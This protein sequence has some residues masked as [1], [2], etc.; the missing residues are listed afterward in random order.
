MK[1]KT[2]LLTGM[3]MGNTLNASEVKTLPTFSETDFTHANEITKNGKTVLSVVLTNSGLEKVK[4][5]NQNGVNK[6]IRFKIDGHVY[7]FKLRE[8]IVA[9]Q[10][11]IGPFSKNEAM[12][13]KK[14]INI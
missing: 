12:R 5:L 3:L 11:I 8:K 7:R 13:I 4:D 2:I 14:E 9:D 10:L 6:K 1:L